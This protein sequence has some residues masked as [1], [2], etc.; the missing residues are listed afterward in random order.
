MNADRGIA[1]VCG[2]IGAF[3]AATGWFSYGLWVNKGPGPGFLPVIFGCFTVIFAIARLLRKDEEAEPVDFKAMIPV[4]AII[5]CLLAIYI[6]GFL[7]AAFL[8]IVFWL[9]HQGSYSYKFSVFLA[10]AI[11]LS[12]WGIFGLWLQVPFPT[13]LISI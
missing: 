5:T 7:P 3:W 8:L 12:I 4:A 10:G 13:G 9:I 2:L 6:I 11:V 1:L